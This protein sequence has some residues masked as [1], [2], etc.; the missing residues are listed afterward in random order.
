MS[1]GSLGDFSVPIKHNLG[2]NLM[3]YTE[4]QEKLYL[5]SNSS[6]KIGTKFKDWEEEIIFVWVTENK[7]S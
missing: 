6:N 1:V 4:M 2:N 5:S 7:S 3:T